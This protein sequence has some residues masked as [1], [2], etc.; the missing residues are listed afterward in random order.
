MKA[1]VLTTRQGGSATFRYNSSGMLIYF[2]AEGLSEDQLLYLLPRLP[3]DQKHIPT[4]N[5]IPRIDIKEV[6]LVISFEDF[7]ARYS[8][9]YGE[10]VDRKKAEA[11]WKRLPKAKQGRAYEYIPAYAARC[12][13]NSIA[14]KMAKT[15][16]NQEPWND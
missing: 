9:F 3:I 11:L 8:S 7:F 15:Y 13:R 5:R 14:L 4:L 12:K 1:Y 16:L 6:P 2:E 10:R